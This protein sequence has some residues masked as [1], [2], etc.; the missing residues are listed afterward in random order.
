ML[1]LERNITTLIRPIVKDG[2]SCV[3]LINKNGRLDEMVCKDGLPLSED[4]KEI[5]YMSIKF[6]SS[7]QSDFDAELQPVYYNVT[8]RGDVKI[9]TIPI[10]DKIVFSLMD[11]TENHIQV[12]EDLHNIFNNPEMF[13]HPSWLPAVAKHMEC[14]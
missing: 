11:K 4:K 8:Q 2:V 10:G 14:Q 7:M 6:L 5:F 3:G 13:S 1:Q 12:V 9:V